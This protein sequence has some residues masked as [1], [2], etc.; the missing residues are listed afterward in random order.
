[1]APCFPE[2]S[3]ATPFFNGYGDDL[4]LLNQLDP[5]AL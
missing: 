1:M 5:L 4:S 2:A 3:E